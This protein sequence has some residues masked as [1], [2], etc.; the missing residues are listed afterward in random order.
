MLRVYITILGIMPFVWLAGCASQLPP[1]PPTIPTPALPLTIT[2]SAVAN[3]TVGT[4]YQQTIQ[5][6]GGTPPFSWSLSAG[7]LPAGLSLGTT[8]S[9]SLPLSG[10][11]VTLET[12]ANFT[13]SVT[14]SRGNTQAQQYTITISAMTQAGTQSGQVQGIVDG[15][16]VA[17]RGIPYAAPPT[18]DLR[19]RPPTPPPSWQGIRD[20]SM[21]GN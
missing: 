3:G 8:S 13:I 21:F 6:T 19:W 12:S 4:A 11:P 10:L 20:A 2:T 14:D 18:G 16:L 15:N 5:A 1:A 7:T 9:E 17:F